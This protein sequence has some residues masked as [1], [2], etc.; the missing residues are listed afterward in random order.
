MQIEQTIGTY[1]K[2]KLN[3]ADIVVVNF[4][5]HI[6]LI[7]WISPKEWEKAV[8]AVNEPTSSS[9]VEDCTEFLKEMGRKFP[10]F[11]FNNQSLEITYQ[12]P[13][14]DQKVHRTLSIAHPDFFQQLDSELDR[15]VTFADFERSA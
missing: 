13:N 4:G 8:K 3:S 2:E 10:S 7:L 11:Q 1:I 12:I 5:D 14:S 15:L 9:N 6:M